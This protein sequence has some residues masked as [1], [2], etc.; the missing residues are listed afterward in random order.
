M[1]AIVQSN[2]LVLLSLALA[3]VG[4]LA[5]NGPFFSLPST[6]LGGAA[7]AGGLGFIN[8]IG[9][10]GRFIGPYGVGVLKESSGGYASAMAAMATAMMISALIVL[11][12]G[13]KMGARK[14]EPS[15]A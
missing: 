4:M 10:L 9:S 7:A 15:R 12:M 11:A 3:M 1:A 8:T 6:F 13:R 14:A 5:Y 2:L